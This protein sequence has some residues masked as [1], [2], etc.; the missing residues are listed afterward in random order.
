MMVCSENRWG[1]LSGAVILGLA[2]ACADG[3]TPSS[4]ALRVRRVSADADAA[5]EPNAAAGDVK[6][7]IGAWLDGKAVQ[8]FYTRSFDCQEPPASVA[9]T[10]C[11]IGALPQDFPRSGPIPVIYAIAPDRVHALRSNDAALSGSS[12]LPE[13]SCDDRRDVSRSPRSDG[14]SARA[15][16]P[17]HHQQ[18]GRLALHRQH[19]RAQSGGVG[20]DVAAPT[21]ETVR[22][23]QAA[24]PEMISGDNMTTFSFS[25]WS[26]RTR[27]SN[28]LTP[29][30]R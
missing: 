3:K 27:R 19:P 2:L 12:A 23:L 18:A 8:L 20:S 15:A 17:H 16:Q 13:S 24:H 4:I 26:T 11:E 7:F 28:W 9:P 6:A 14:R 22:Q 21:L 30:R 29:R 10:G 1:A 5:G 25:S